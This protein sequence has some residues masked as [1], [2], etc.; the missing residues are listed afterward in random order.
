MISFPQTVFKSA[1]NIPHL[2][3]ST[4]RGMNQ[5]I[6]FTCTLAAVCL[7]RVHQ[8]QEP[9][10]VPSAIWMRIM[11]RTNHFERSLHL[12]FLKHLKVI[13][14]LSGGNPDWSIVA[15]LAEMLLAVD[16]LEFSTILNFCFA[17][18]TSVIVSTVEGMRDGKQFRSRLDPMII[19]DGGHSKFWW[20]SL[21]PQIMLNNTTHYST[22]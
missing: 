6:P 15:G 2:L 3:H 4:H 8:I 16:R 10:P 17:Y 9:R 11:T 5:I 14:N 7:V 18:A 21:M 13:W 19:E 12:R 22:E 20:C 1:Q